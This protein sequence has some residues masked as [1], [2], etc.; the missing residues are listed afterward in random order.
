MQRHVGLI[1]VDP[2][3]MRSRRDVKCLTWQEIDAHAIF[4]QDDAVS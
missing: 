3:V 1:A 4:I 2:T